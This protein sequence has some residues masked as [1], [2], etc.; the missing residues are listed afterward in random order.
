MSVMEAATHTRLPGALVVRKEECPIVD[1]GPANCGAELI[2]MKGLARLARGVLEKI[3]GIQL[4]IAQ[5]LEQRPVILVGSAFDRG[6]DDGA[7][8]M[9]EFRRE[10]AGFDFELNLIRSSF[11]LAAIFVNR[12]SYSVL[13]LVIFF[14]RRIC[15]KLF[16]RKVTLRFIIIILVLQVI[17]KIIIIFVRQ[18]N[19]RRSRFILWMF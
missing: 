8:G 5:K 12:A 10:G 4:V 16:Q 3:V 9:S 14:I 7:R 11:L 2:L 13:I 17:Y 19:L 6:I 15:F 18:R 1:D